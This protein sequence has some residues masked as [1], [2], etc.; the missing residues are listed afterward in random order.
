MKGDLLHYSYY[1][2]AEHQERIEKY[3]TLGAS[4]LKNSSK[5]SLLLKSFFSPLLR[6]LKM[7]LFQRGFLDGKAGLQVCYY[8]SKEVYLKYAK[9][10]QAKNEQSI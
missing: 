8:V 4:K 9:A 5:V 6:F 10:Y 1:S 3:A 2:V 7:Y